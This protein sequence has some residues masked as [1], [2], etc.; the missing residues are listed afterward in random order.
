MERFTNKYIREMI[1]T[2]EVKERKNMGCSTLLIVGILAPI[3]GLI[4]M[5]GSND[6]GIQLL[7]GFILAIGVGAIFIS[8]LLTLDK[9]YQNNVE[10][11]FASLTDEQVKI[12]DDELNRGNV[13]QYKKF[14]IILTA[15]FL[16]CFDYMGFLI[17]NYN[18]I[19]ELSLLS[20][21]QSSLNRYSRIKVLKEDNKSHVISRFEYYLERKF[22]YEIMDKIAEKNPNIV[23]VKK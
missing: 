23:V 16:I 8:P 4:I 10:K 2:D 1:E 3:F 14:G 6:S 19:K 21:K 18:E 20:F 11:F 22:A 12:L 15:S 17:L 7:G 5:T 13:I 9:G